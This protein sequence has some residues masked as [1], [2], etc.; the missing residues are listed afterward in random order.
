MPSGHNGSYQQA[1][2]HPEVKMYSKGLCKSCYYRTIR[3]D[4]NKEYQKARHKK[5]PELKKRASLKVLGWTL[6]LFNKTLIEQNNKCAICEKEV[7]LSKVQN[8]ARACADHIHTSPPVHRGILCSPCNAMIGQ[9]QES[10][11]ILRAAALYIEKFLL[12]SPAEV[13]N[14]Q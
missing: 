10:A 11:R 6:E 12:E 5:N 14:N 9:A 8:D 13:V 7:N 2:C 3:S 4:Y 1:I